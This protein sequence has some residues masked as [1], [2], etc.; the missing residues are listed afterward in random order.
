MVGDVARGFN[1][2]AADIA[3]DM[4]GECGD[5]TV[6]D[7]GAGEGTYARR[8]RDLGAQVIAVEPTETLLEAAQRTE[9]R[10]PLGIR[11]FADRAEDMVNV[12][13]NSVD[14]VVAVLVLHHIA[15]LDQ[16]LSEVA[17]VLRPDGRLIA[18]VPHP[19]AD[20]SRATWQPSPEGPRR[21]V[22]DYV[23]EGYWQTDEA[24]SIRSVGWYHRTI[25]TWVKALVAAGFVLVEVREPTGAEPRRPDGGGPWSVVPRFLAFSARA[26]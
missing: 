4:L 23:I 12:A 24:G 18:V 15:H 20:H 16:A 9:E 8:L 13:T 22:G 17:R 1:H 11:Y 7:V 2:L 6:L 3:L 10:T 19:W 26:R 14:A 5:Q 25:A 21:L